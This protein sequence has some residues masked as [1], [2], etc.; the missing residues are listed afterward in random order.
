[1]EFP[2]KEYGHLMCKY[3]FLDLVIK[4]RLTYIRDRICF[5]LRRL[6]IMRT[7]MWVMDLV[8]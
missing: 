6:P 8:Y 2:I 3:I 1:M 7:P 5:Q 4:S